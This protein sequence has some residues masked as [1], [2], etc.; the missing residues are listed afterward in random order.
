MSD[1]RRRLELLALI[2]IAVFAACALS[3]QTR[4][5][6]HGGERELQHPKPIVEGSRVLIFACDGAG[7]D[8]MMEAI[9]SG[10]MPHLAG[11]L[12]K[13]QSDTT[14]EHAYSAPAAISILPST[15]MA[16][17]SSIFTGAPPAYTGVPGNE[18]FVREDMKFYAPAPVSIQDTDDTVE[19]I[20][21][22]LVGRSLKTP[23]L[24]QQAGVRSAV[25][26]NPVH[27]GADIYTTAKTS[28]YA[29]LMGNFIK[30]ELGDSRESKQNLY[31][32]LDLE[33]VPKVVDA[34][35]A[36]GV[37]DIQV[38]Y[39]PGIDLYT[40]LAFPS[41][42]K[43]EVEYLE[44]VTDPCIGTILDAYQS[45]NVLDRTYVIIVADHGHTPVLKDSKHALGAEHDAS[46]PG[47][48]EHAG[49]RL[50]PWVL[51]PDSS[52]QDYQA[53]FAYQG[54]IGYIYLADRSTCPKEGNKCDW[55]R[56][57][58]FNEDVMPALRAIDGTNRTG[59]GNPNLKGTVDLI[60]SRVPTPKGQDTR[61]FEIFDGTK[62]VPINDYLAAHPRPDLIELDR[63]MKWLSAGPYG[64]RAGDILLLSKSGLDRPI[65]G[66]FY[67]SGPY[68]SWHG[69]PSRQD[70]HIPLILAGKSETGD[71]LRGRMA[72][73]TRN[74]PE[75]PSQLDVVPLVRALIGR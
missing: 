60:F 38:V 35:N 64:N 44:T 36:H 28:S 50:R 42:L 5:L 74:D 39:F 2:A 47:V 59:N 65:D 3:P 6:L 1:S 70:S 16:A 46:F 24:F 52:H 69:S 34:L 62:L 11:F 13:E 26:L 67:F 14:F 53:A 17:W 51:N 56:P 23:T 73:V 22:D 54:A 20:A 37:P 68:H 58:R 27:R 31:A 12:G 75:H 21:H 63:R 45:H 15:T 32:G 30:G 72:A 49:F 10:K 41:P 29:S 7:Y 8:Q 25:S 18:W 57:P 71:Q 40:H 55:A 43:Q 33:S 19:M 4:L 48:V 61:E 9:R 66:R